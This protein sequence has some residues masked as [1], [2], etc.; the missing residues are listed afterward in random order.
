VGR[1]RADWQARAIVAFIAVGIAARLIRYLLR[2]PLWAD[3]S[4]LA[5]NLLHRG[6]ADLMRPLDC[7]QV[8]PLLFLWTE[9]TAVKLLGFS[10]WSLRLFPL[11][12]GI[13]S[14][15]LFHR[16]AR[17]LVRG[18]ALVLAVGIF[19]VNYSG[20]RYACETKPYGVDL[21][22]STLILLLTVRWWKQPG[23]TGRLWA[24]TA[25]MPLALGLSFPAM[26][27][28]GGASVAIAAALLGSP[29]RRGWAAWVAYNIVLCGGF[30]AWYWLGIRVQAQ[31][32]MGVMTAGWGDAFPPRDSLI[33]LAI[34]LVRVHAG[35]LLAVPVGG[36]NWGSTA[37]LLL[38][39]VAAIV[40]L[41]QAR[42]RL[43]LLF[44]APFALN[45][46]AAALRLY[47]YGGHMRLAMHLVPIICLLAGIGTAAVLSPLSFRERVRETD[48]APSDSALREPLPRPITIVLA[49]LMTL[50]TAF[51]ARDFYQPGKEPSDI[52][53]RDFAAWFWS[54]LERGHEVLCLADDLPAPLPPL[55]KSGQGRAAPQ[56][57]CNEQIYSPRH[58][59]GTSYDLA[60][61]SRD[62][63]LACVQYWWHSAPYDPAEFSRWLDTM[64]MRY[65]LIATARY[66]LLQDNDNDRQPEPA[67]RIEVYEFAP[68]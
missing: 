40:L 39:L 54:G 18:T 56:F 33:A 25:I 62:R 43:L 63:P 42:Y 24:L 46:L 10:E 55:S 13:A 6:Y 53:K 47:P 27:V 32:E 61:V 19:A 26:F 66:P 28:A 44:A 37:T 21:M 30:L 20:I 5:V 60:R 58:V 11:L 16:L 51:L 29:S 34:W 14:V 41:R 67:D 49:L 68:K 36:D 17:H 52:R 57:L 4:Y 3:E 7:H 59:H 45:M 35:P 12:S 9:L 31:A 15:F 50:A 8:A 23:E 65:S 1:D 38:C 22:I 2:F 64:Q 48:L